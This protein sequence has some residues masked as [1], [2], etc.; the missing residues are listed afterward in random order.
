MQDGVIR[1]FIEPDEPEIELKIQVKSPEV[2][3]GMAYFYIEIEDGAPVSFQ[4][5]ASFMGP[6]VKCHNPNIDFGLIK[7]NS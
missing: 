3:Q 4:V 6:I 1:G 5:Q 7:V 2:G